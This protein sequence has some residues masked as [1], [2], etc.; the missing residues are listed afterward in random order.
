[1]L[2]LIEKT[3]IK[4]LKQSREKGTGLY[5]FK[6][7]SVAGDQKPT[8]CEVFYS[9]QLVGEA[10]WSFRL[11]EALQYKLKGTNIHTFLLAI[12]NNDGVSIS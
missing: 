6:D 3:S 9:L 4:Q 8:I 1:M 11:T 2:K 12:I 7:R 10:L 5:L